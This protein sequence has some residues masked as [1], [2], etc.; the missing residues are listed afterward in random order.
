VIHLGIIL[1][2]VAIGAGT[3]LTVYAY[4]VMVSSHLHS[5]LPPWDGDAIKESPSFQKWYRLLIY[6]LGYAGASYRSSVYASIST[7]N[8]SHVSEAGSK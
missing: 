2:Q 3:V 1:L 7:D 4:I 6:F 8:G 5:L